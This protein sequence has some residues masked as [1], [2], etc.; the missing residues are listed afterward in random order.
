[1]IGLDATGYGTEFLCRTCADHVASTGR[2]NSDLVGALG[3]QAQFGDLTLSGRGRVFIPV[4]SLREAGINSHNCIGI[5]EVH[6][7]EV[8]TTP[9]LPKAAAGNVGRER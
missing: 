7:A 9:G 6:P 4:K 5:G 3:A 8:R 2:T 1:M